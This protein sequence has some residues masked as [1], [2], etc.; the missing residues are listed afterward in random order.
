MSEPS[1]SIAYIGRAPSS[2]GTPLF[3]GYVEVIRTGQIAAETDGAIPLHDA[4]EWARQHTPTVVLSYGLS[5]A[6]VFSAGTTYYDG[7][8]AGNPLPPWPP[9]SEIVAA[10]DA[11]VASARSRRAN[12]DRLTV[13]DPVLE[14]VDD[15]HRRAGDD[16]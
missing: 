5:G 13:V 8:N 12:R 14:N 11:E 4:L 3:R 2:S 1:E 10:I 15:S 9:S 7:G 16:E 6:H